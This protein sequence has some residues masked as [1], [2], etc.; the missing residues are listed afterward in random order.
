MLSVTRL[1]APLARTLN[2]QIDGQGSLVMEG[3]GSASS[4][5]MY[6]Y[7]YIYICI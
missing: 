5:G 6:I 1:N 4:Q 2:L 7:M 3:D